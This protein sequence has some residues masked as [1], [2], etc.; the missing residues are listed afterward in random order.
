MEDVFLYWYRL[1]VVWL[2]PLPAALIGSQDIA[3]FL[4]RDAARANLIGTA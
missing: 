4:S 1:L 3:G 2:G